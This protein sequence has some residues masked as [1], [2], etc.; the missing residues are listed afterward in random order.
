VSFSSTN[1]LLGC[2]FI[3]Q[4]RRK[5]ESQKLILLAIWLRARHCLTIHCHSAMRLKSLQ[6]AG[7]AH[8]LPVRNWFIDNQGCS[9]A[10]SQLLCW[11]GRCRIRFLIRTTGPRCIDG[12]QCERRIGHRYSVI[13]NK[14][15]LKGRRR[16]LCFARQFGRTQPQGPLKVCAFARSLASPATIIII[17]PRSRPPPPT[18]P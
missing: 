4:L 9:L 17:T 14:V 18:A 1:K 13:N 12:G 3:K 5:G 15:E 16:A 11:R 7:G 8:K 2:R 6:I 10:V